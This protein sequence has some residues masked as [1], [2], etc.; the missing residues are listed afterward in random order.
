MSDATGKR[1]RRVLFIDAKT[2]EPLGEHAVVRGPASAI[3]VSKNR[4][5]VAGGTA[6]KPAELRLYTLDGPRLTDRTNSNS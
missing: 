4:L 3:A 6:G 5:A 1:R 2:G